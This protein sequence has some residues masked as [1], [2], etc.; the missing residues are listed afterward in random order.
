MRVYIGGSLANDDIPR[1]TKLVA[2]AGH[3]AFSEW[4][5]PGPEADVNWRT[6]EQSL[7]YDFRQAL[8][9]PSAQHI[10]NF[11]KK[12]IDKSDMFVMVLPCGKSAHLELGYARGTGKQTVIYM[13]TEPEKWDV[14]Y[15]FAD[16]IVI[17][18]DELWSILNDGQPYPFG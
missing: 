9:R 8:L 14:M 3:D 2:E 1:I 16:H 18:D 4:F 13:P 11:D 15:A 7:G 12:F 10:F 17:G 6:Y 5:T